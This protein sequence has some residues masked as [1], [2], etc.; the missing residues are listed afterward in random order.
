VYSKIN[1]VLTDFVVADNPFHNFEHASHVAQSV[2]KLLG[3]I[4]APDLD[5]TIINTHTNDLGS[6]LHDHTYGI[7]SDPLTQF[8][9]VFSALIHDVD[10]RGLPNTELAKEDPELASIYHNKSIAEQHS[11]HVAWDL[12]MGEEYANLRHSIYRTEEEHDRFRRL[13]VNSVMATDIMDAD[14]K[15]NRNAR[16]DRAFTDR[17]QSV[18]ESA[19]QTIDRKATIVIEHLIQASDVAHTMQHWHVYRRW[20][21]CLFLEMF[22][23]FR[24]GRSDRNPAEFWYDGEIGFYDFYIIPL[25]KKLK[26]CGVFGVSSDEY[27]N[28]ALKNRE[29][30]ETRGREIVAEMV[31]MAS[32]YHF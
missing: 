31:E 22:C 25:A 11:I 18:V 29:E 13:V 15:R 23:A 14:L 20:N 3:R 5:E 8:A 27:L 28:Y 7:T 32:N 24:D 16:W 17:P 21:E 1:H 6:A 4:I 12:L 26:E 30:W 2:I 9:C 10:H 19:K